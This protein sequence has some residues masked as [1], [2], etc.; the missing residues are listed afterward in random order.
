MD[1]KF[2]KCLLLLGL[3]FVAQYAFAYNNILNLSLLNFSSYVMSLST[4]PAWQNNGESQTFYLYPNI[5]KT[6]HAKD[7]TNLLW[8]GELFLGI[9][10]NWCATWQSQLG[11]AFAAAGK[12]NLKGEIWDDADP[13]FNNYSYHYHVNH[14]HIALKG[15]ILKDMGYSVIPWV[16]ASIGIG[17]NK[18]Q[19]FA[20][21]P[22][23]QEAVTMPNF[24]S[25]TVTAFSYN[26]GIGVQKIISNTWQIGIGYEFNDWGQSQL[27]RAEGQTIG[28]G[29]KL[30]HLYTNGLVV[31]L[32]ALI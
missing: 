19:G 32:T 9:Q 21:T 24:V 5:E 3:N 29:L 20:N 7:T 22:T 11:L 12:A 23:I 25:K 13:Q 27:G 14:Q 6:Y 8:N 17:F 31:N 18:A 10:K 28:K 4:G 30:N 16:S 15:K 26:I 2:E 1:K